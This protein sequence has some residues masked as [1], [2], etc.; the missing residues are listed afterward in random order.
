L[1]VHKNDRIASGFRV[2]TSDLKSLI[3]DLKAAS[4]AAAKGLRSVVKDAA[5]II[6]VE[7]RSIAAEHSTSIPPT[8]KARTYLSGGKTSAATVT[9][10]KGVSLAA[11]YEL[12]NK[13]KP[14]TA[15][16]FRHPVF[17]RGASGR[18]QQTDDWVDQARYP[19]LKP[20]ADN[21]GAAVQVALEKV[22]DTVTDIIAVR[23]L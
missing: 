11:L 12:G 10:G 14:S 16:T 5:E 20:A 4:P 3:K 1:A 13:G 19:F 9:A 7:A 21:K 15:A 17:E 8:I 18:L 23:K 22:A 2:D 6:A